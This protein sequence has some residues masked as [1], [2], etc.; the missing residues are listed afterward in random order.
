MIT[1]EQ[2]VDA[3][4]DVV[5]GNEDYI[6]EEHY[7]HC[8]YTDPETGTPACL[9]GHVLSKVDPDLLREISRFRRDNEAGWGS[10]SSGFGVD[11][12]P[13]ASAILAE[14]QCAQDNGS[15]WGAALDRA[16]EGWA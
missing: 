2:V 13:K 9:V 16:L 4:K 7:E 14:V 3:L 15:S 5:T 1:K 8:W 11:I 10:V 6:Y 12:D